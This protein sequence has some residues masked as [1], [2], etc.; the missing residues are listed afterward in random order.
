[1]SDDSMP[2]QATAGTWSPTAKQAQA[3]DDVDHVLTA[4]LETPCLGWA[5]PDDIGYATGLGVIRVRAAL[6]TLAMA[7]DVE[8]VAQGALWRPTIAAIRKHRDPSLGRIPLGG[9]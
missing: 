3:A 2:W 1:M 9:R 7:G 5:S 4:V 6:E 8:S